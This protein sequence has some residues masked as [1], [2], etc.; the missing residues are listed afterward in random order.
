MSPTE[1]RGAVAGAIGGLA[2]AAGLL[3]VVLFTAC[4]ALN[5]SAVDVITTPETTVPDETH[6]WVDCYQDPDTERW[7]PNLAVPAPGECP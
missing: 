1:R 2:L 6:Q 3:L 4:V 7:V 5:G